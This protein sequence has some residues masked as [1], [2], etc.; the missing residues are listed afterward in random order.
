MYLVAGLP[1]AWFAASNRSPLGARRDLPPER[2]FVKQFGL[3]PGEYRRTI[4]NA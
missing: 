4:R 1:V 2:A 3:T